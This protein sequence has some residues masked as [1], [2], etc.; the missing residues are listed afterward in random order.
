M[1]SLWVDIALS[2]TALQVELS[3]HQPSHLA[4]LV[5]C[6]NC[7]TVQCGPG[8]RSLFVSGTEEPFGRAFIRKEQSAGLSGY[9][10]E[11]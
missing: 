2:S 4:V 5:Q 8:S 1:C 10:S 7:T 9:K 6:I 11:A 3:P